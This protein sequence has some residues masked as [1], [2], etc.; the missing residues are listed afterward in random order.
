MDFHDDEFFPWCIFVESSQLQTCNTTSPS[1]LVLTLL[2]YLTYL[3]ILINFLYFLHTFVKNVKAVKKERIKTSLI[4][5]LLTTV[6]YLHQEFRSMLSSQEQIS[7]KL[8][9]FIIFRQ[10]YYNFFKYFSNV[11]PMQEFSLCLYVS[12]S[13]D[14]S[15]EPL[16]SV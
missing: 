9:D 1:A 12:C 16:V 7:H 15:V 13:T 3:N 4:K 6:Y 5:I 11:N 8:R 2:L 14:V 10:T